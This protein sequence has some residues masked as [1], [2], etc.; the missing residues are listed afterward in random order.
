MASILRSTKMV[1]AA[2]S[3]AKPNPGNTITRNMSVA[4][5]ACTIG[6][7]LVGSASQVNARNGVSSSPSITGISITNSTIMMAG[8][9]TSTISI[10]PQNALSKSDFMNSLS[11]KSGAMTDISGRPPRASS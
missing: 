5:N 4:M 6:S 9:P 11:L 3:A 1:P 7:V 10:S 8:S 2:S